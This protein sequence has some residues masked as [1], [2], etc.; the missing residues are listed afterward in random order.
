LELFSLGIIGLQ[1][2]MEAKILLYILELA[3]PIAI[4]ME[5]LTSVP[6]Q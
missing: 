6:E 1:Q 2:K 4:A 5:M 3:H